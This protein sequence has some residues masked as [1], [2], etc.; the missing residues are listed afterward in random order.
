MGADGDVTV[1]D[2]ELEWVPAVSESASK[3]K[4]NP[5]FGWKLKGRAVAT[6]VGGKVAWRL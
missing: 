5:F 3:S 1:F 2:P 6:V 4:N